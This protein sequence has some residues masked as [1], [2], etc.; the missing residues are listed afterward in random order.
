MCTVWVSLVVDVFRES[1]DSFLRERSAMKAEFHRVLLVEDEPLTRTWLKSVLEREGY[2]VASVADA[3]E[4]QVAIER[5]CPNFLIT[6]LQMPDTDGMQLCHWLRTLNLPQY[7]Y[8]LVMTADEESQS[9]TGSLTAGADDFFRKPVLREELV[10]RLASGARILK[11]EAKLREASCRDAL[12][13]V[14]NRGAFFDMLEREWE[15]SVRHNS[16][17][18]AVMLDLDYFK[19]INDQY[20]HFAG[21]QVLTAVTERLRETTRNPDL[22]GRYGGEEFCLLLPHTDRQGAIVCA[23]RCRAAISATPVRIEGAAIEI[24]ASFGV[25]IR[26]PSI[27]NGQQFIEAADQALLRAKRTGRNK[28]TAALPAASVSGTSAEATVLC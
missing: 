1:P 12:T 8:V 14:L 16:E 5:D 21:D 26:S 3:G 19:S 24:T 18:A 13:Q 17:L 9:L 20:G 23:E 4:A 25:A 10:A 11:L 22:I 7:V 6:G 15:L 27:R 2:Q 28:V